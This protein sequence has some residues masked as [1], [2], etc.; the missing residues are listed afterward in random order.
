MNQAKS[1]A[2]LA[3]FAALSVVGAADVWLRYGRDNSKSLQTAAERLGN[4]PT[5]IGNWEGVETPLDDIIVRVAGCSGYRNLR[6]THALTGRSVD[7]TIM[8]GLPGQMSEHVPEVCYP[9]GGYTLVQSSVTKKSTA[10]LSSNVQ[11]E[12]AVMDFVNPRMTDARTRVWH[13]WHDGAEWSRPNRPRFAFVR[14]AALVRLQVWSTLVPD[15]FADDK[16]GY[17]DAGEEFLTD[18]LATLT[19]VFAGFE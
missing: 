2:L 5:K 10:A 4:I 18:A 8:V 14:A 3:A 13:G 15:P 19:T 1:A 6:Y 16:K 11:R 17:V 12:L 9:A 7:V